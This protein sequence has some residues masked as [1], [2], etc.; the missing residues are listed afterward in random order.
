MSLIRLPYD[1]QKKSQEYVA[2]I[3]VVYIH[4]HLR[5]RTLKLCTKFHFVLIRII[6]W[7]RRMNSCIISFI[8]GID[9]FWLQ[10]TMQRGGKC[11][12][13]KWCGKKLFVSRPNRNKAKLNAWHEKAK[14]TSHLFYIQRGWYWNWNFNSVNLKWWM[15]RVGEIKHWPHHSIHALPFLSVFHR[16]LRCSLF[17]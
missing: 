3:W 10:N 12:R 6:S 17:A 5:L 2:Y 9:S 13:C 7:K 4:T 15:S 8:C 14:Q 1:S 11:W 16:S